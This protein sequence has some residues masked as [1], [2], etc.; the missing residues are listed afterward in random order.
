MG[1]LCA[2]FALTGR[3]ARAQEAPRS[4]APLILIVPTRGSSSWLAAERRLVAELRGLELRVG[5]DQVVR[6]FDT[7]LPE[8]AHFARA[9]VAIQ[10][11][12]EADLGILRFWFEQQPGRQAGYQHLEVNL[13]NADVV[14][15]AV[16]PVVEAIFDRVEAPSGR[17]PVRPS[18]VRSGSERSRPHEDVDDCVR[19]RDKRCAPGVAG[20]L[21]LTPYVATAAPGAALAVGAG[22][23]WRMFST[24][25]LEADADYH[26]LAKRTTISPLSNQLT[27]SVLSNQAAAAM[28]V[29]Y[30]L[31]NRMGR[32]VAIGPGFGAFRASHD[33]Q[34]LWAPRA[35][36]R[37]E[38]FVP[39]GT[40]TDLSVGTTVGHVWGLPAGTEHGGTFVSLMLGLD[41][42]VN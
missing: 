37:A 13:R 16:L 41:L 19:N 29:L 34:P 10:V 3:V 8:R 35:S 39:L 21:L 33:G 2:L 42:N 24:L 40:R 20:R 23:R 6:E 28:H 12:R 9:M 31:R 5:Y 38:L 14:S 32:G 18:T 11:L 25:T 7:R 17:L 27:T 15:R 30:E 1:A 26:V 22:V 36:L 4:S